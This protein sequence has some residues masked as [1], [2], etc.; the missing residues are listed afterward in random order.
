MEQEVKEKKIVLITGVS[1]GIGKAIVYQL[2]LR[3]DIQIIG[4][5]RTNPE[6]KNQQFTFIKMDLS[7]PESIRR[8]ITQLEKERIDVFI[9]NAG[10]GIR[11]TI[12]ELPIEKIKDQ[13]EIN[14][15][16]P[17]I[18]LQKLLPN[19]IAN[20]SIIINIGALGALIETPTM[21][22][23]TVSKLAYS[24]LLEILKIESNLRIHNLYLG[25]VK[26]NFGKNIKDGVD[27]EKSKYKNLYNEWQNRFKNFFMKRNR[28]EDVAL[29]IERI[30]FDKSN[31]EF[32]SRRDKFI[33]YSNRF[34]PK[35][36]H[37]KII[38]YFYKYES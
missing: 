23:Y 6:I 20:Q 16:S 5:G 14:F 26:S 18:I 32:I 31:E 7:D 28:A 30:I 9:N 25:A 35:L 36:I 1:G 2:L 13:F 29:L 33:A 11:G 22:Y 19:F 37:K 15:F 27:I 4:L 12:E 38:N 21:G 17:V 34:L 24:K 8:V 10:S 3:T